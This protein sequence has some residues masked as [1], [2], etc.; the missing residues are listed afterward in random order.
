MGKKEVAVYVPA[1]MDDQGILDCLGQNGF[2][3][4][5]YQDERIMANQARGALEAI[6]IVAGEDFLKMA[7]NIAETFKE[8]PTYVSNPLRDPRVLDVAKA[9][10]ITVLDPSDELHDLSRCLGVVSHQDART[11]PRVLIVDDNPVDRDDIWEVIRDLADVDTA[12]CSEEALQRLEGPENLYAVVIADLHLPKDK[13]SSE[14]DPEN[15]L[16]VLGAVGRKS[17]AT[18]SLIITDHYGKDYT[19]THHHTALYRQGAVSFLFKKDALEQPSIL[20]NEV[21]RVIGEYRNRVTRQK[22]IRSDKEMGFDWIVA[23]DERVLAII[24]QLQRIAGTSHGTRNHPLMLTGGTGTGKELLARGFA[25]LHRP[26]GPFVPIN[27][28]HIARD[29]GSAMT[30]Q[31]FGTAEK[32]FTGVKP[33]DGLLFS[34]NNGVV[35]LDEIQTLPVEIQ[36]S[37]LTVMEN[38]F[39]PP[40]NGLPKRTNIDIQFVLA[41]NEPERLT[42]DLRN[43]VS[44]AI[45]VPTL[46]ERTDLDYLVDYFVHSAANDRGI[47]ISGIERDAMKRLQEYSWP[48]NIRQLY[49]VTGRIVDTSRWE[50]NDGRIRLPDV[51]ATLVEEYT[52]Y[53]TDRPIEQGTELP[54]AEQVPSLDREARRWFDR[55]MDGHRVNHLEI[56][57]A[58]EVPGISREERKR[59]GY[60]LYVRV[61][62]LLDAERKLTMGQRSNRDS[63]ISERTHLVDTNGN[64]LSGNTVGKTLANART[65]LV[66]DDGS[67]TGD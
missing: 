49:Y 20:A 67:I 29:G 38:D 56:L 55:I 6:V 42:V 5:P 45:D 23:R 65:K 54:E 32:F 2:P 40:I 3:V 9:R 14:T 12:D 36:D 63:F 60:S 8:T 53:S 7:S 28:A 25:A 59:F 50:R 30:A 41:T 64:R 11:L 44:T 39:L 43:R 37:L 4:F 46:R 27:C 21:K 18:Q 51:D 22:R 16:A 13:D 1:G 19:Y 66:A 26:N 35:F 15:G 61:W 57:D 48:G 47:T 31:L 58:A 17:A 33:H 24:E 52:K 10:G 34:A 62:D